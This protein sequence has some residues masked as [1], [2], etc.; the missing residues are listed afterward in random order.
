M[1]SDHIARHRPLFTF[2]GSME[3]A[4]SSDTLVSSHVTTWYHNLEDCDLLN[5]VKMFDVSFPLFR[6]M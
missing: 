4:W 6:L 5:A 2:V 3:A 1:H